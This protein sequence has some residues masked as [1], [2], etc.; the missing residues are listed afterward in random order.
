[1]PVPNPSIRNLNTFFLASLKNA[2][3]NTTRSTMRRTT[4][5]QQESPPGYSC[6]VV[7]VC[8]PAKCF[9]YFCYT[10]HKRKSNKP[11]GVMV[12]VKANSRVAIHFQALTVDSIVAL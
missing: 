10:V 9:I 8:E 1:M 2:M 5:S 3:R 11:S 4:R 12:E 7:M 6:Y